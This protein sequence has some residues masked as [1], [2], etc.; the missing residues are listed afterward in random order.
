MTDTRHWEDRP[1]S[2]C[3]RILAKCEDALNWA[4]SISVFLLMAVGVFQVFGRQLFNLPISGYID[5]VE[6]V[7][8]IYAFFGLAYCQR[9]GSH[10]RM[11]M[12]LGRLKGRVLWGNETALT[13]VSMLVIGALALASWAHFLRAY[14]LGDSSI[15]LGLP[16]WPAKLAVSVALF[17]LWLRLVIE[18]LG[19]L[20]QFIRPDSKPLGVPLMQ[21][22]REK[23]EEQIRDALG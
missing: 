10:V 6:L 18:F 17:F 19:F 9:F 13:F 8:A 16:I 5:V 7:A 14:Q 15:D 4:A 23:A 12:V 11:E 22:V 20:R 2:A 1:L 3:N 21:D